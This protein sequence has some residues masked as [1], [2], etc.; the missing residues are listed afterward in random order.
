VTPKYVCF[1]LRPGERVL[2]LIGLT[3]QIDDVGRSPNPLVPLIAPAADDVEWLL[4]GALGSQGTAATRRT[5]IHDKV[6]SGNPEMIF[7]ELNSKLY[8]QTG[9]VSHLT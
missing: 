6:S 3:Q 9:A 8:R 7:A 4:P 1:C 2:T 5:I